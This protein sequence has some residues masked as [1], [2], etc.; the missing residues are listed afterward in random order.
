MAE[1]WRALGKNVLVRPDFEQVKAVDGIVKLDSGI[2][3]PATSVD[4]EP[5]RGGAV[6][7]IGPEVTTQLSVGDWVFFSRAGSLDDERK[8][9]NTFYHPKL[10]RL[11][12]REED[13]VAVRVPE[14]ELVH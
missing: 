12:V 9:D 2:S 13:I 11:V 10:V 8:A 3:V 1:R 14:K 7:S 6:V 5:K 4:K